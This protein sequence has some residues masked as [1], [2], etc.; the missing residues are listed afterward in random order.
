MHGP[1]SKQ[2]WCQTNACLAQ[3]AWLVSSSLSSIHKTHTY[4]RNV[5]TG[6]RFFVF[7]CE[8]CMWKWHLCNETC[9]KLFSSINI[10]L[11]IP[12]CCHVCVLSKEVI[13]CIK[14]ATEDREN[15]A[16]EQNFTQIHILIVTHLPLYTHMRNWIWVPFTFSWKHNMWTM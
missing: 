12:P 8:N 7:F 5:A 14:I 2:R 4:S 13:N 9:V 15:I 10:W 1:P 16:R 3:A 11:L 6:S